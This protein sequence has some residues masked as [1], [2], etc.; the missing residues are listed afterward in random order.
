MI[1]SPHRTHFFDFGSCDQGNTESYDQKSHMFLCS[2]TESAVM[3]DGIIPDFFPVNTGVCQRCALDPLLF[4]TCMNH[5]LGTKS[6]CGMSYGTDRIT[7][8]DSAHDA[9][10][11]AETT[12]FLAEA[13]ESLS[14]GAEQLGL[15]VSWMKTKVQAIGDILDATVETIPA[16]SENVE[17]TQ[18]F[19]HLVSMIYS[20]T[21]CDPEVN[22]RL[23]RA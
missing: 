12:D 2:D 5:V 10:T 20:A 8:P 3:C 16:S 4:S 1:V 21:N 23:G 17:I 9:V 6:G 11:F 7:D 18:T 14:E 22:R 15:R 13:L 19:T